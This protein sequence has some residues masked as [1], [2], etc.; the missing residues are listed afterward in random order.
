MRTRP[1]VP[2]GVQVVDK[3]RGGTIECDVAIIGGGP[4]G[5]TCGALLK[6]YAP[7]LRVVIFEKE[8]F[9][10]D[11]IGE[12][13][14][15]PIS[16]VLDEMGCWDKVEAANFPIKVGAT[17]KWGSR[18][19]LWDF[20]FL[21]LKDFKNEPRPAKFV[22]QRRQT[23]FQVDR[24]IY[25]DILL[26]HAESLGCEV[27]EQTQVRR[28]EHEGDRVTGLTLADGRR[29][30]ARHY[31]DSSG[32]VGVMRRALGIPVEAPTALQNIAIWDY[33]ENA[34]WAV[35][36]GVGGTRIQIVSIDF[37]WIWFIPLG[38]TRTSVGL[39][40]PAKFYKES[41][42][43]ARQLYD[44]ALSREDRL[45]G[46]LA[47]ATARGRLET[48]SDWSF[49]A[50]RTVGE[51]WML[52]GE[53]AGFADPILSAGLTLTHT[54]AREAAYTIIALDAGEHNADWLRDQYDHNQRARVRQHIRF[55]DFWYAANAQFTDLQA[56]CA[57]IARESG[58]RLTPQ[59]AWRWLAQ[60]G[61]SN[62]FIGQVGIGGYDLTAAKQ[63]LQMFTQRNASWQLNEVNVLRLNL[64]GA[65]RQPI[66]LYQD[67]RIEAIDC[68]IKGHLRLPVA[69]MHARLI[70][71]LGTTSNVGEI[72][73]SLEREFAATLP[74]PHRRVAM[75]HAM[76]TLEVMLNDGWVIGKLDKRKPRLSLETPEEGD[77]IHSHDQ[78]RPRAG[79]SPAAAG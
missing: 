32:H 11:H 43:T 49:V 38:P 40:C 72:F 69:D 35:H 67:G 1:G 52:V 2:C 60:G 76:Q 28:V 50:D 7:S 15:P 48:T 34:E 68:Y 73:T 37:G 55:A 30:E 9:P 12:S 3:V 19:E 77:I 18:G 44:E 59:A 57:E 8:R 53:A 5:S 66:A 21:P 4:G 26:R 78:P 61:F 20:E 31:V 75:Q 45:R 65:E 16:A 46:L 42:R 54:G 64:T 22:G 17:F 10:R 62:D 63:L 74:P 79:S 71:M 51:N 29:V 27:H 70:R 23:A 58:L 25:D 39:V 6:K 14:L 56:H 33:W 36:I 41:G 24:A 47:N 13:Q